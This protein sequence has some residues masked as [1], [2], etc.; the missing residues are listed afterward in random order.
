M[1]VRSSMAYIIQAIRDLIND[2][3]GATQHFTDQAVQDR[4]D[5]MR[6]DLYQECLESADTL[7]STGTIEWHDFF[8]E[9]G[10]WETDYTIQKLNGA[11]VTPTTSEPLIGRWTFATN[12]TEP[13]VING[14]V[15][16][17]YGVASALLN[18]WVAEERKAITSWTADGTTIQRLNNMKSLNDLAETYAM[19]AWGW[20]RGKFTQVKLVRKDLRN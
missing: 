18:T 6:L 2:P 12:Q 7:T 13:L 14:K 17:V 9:F 16:N 5:L 1:A 11:S 10:F 19:R 4:L 3:A 8:S 15:Y 20:G